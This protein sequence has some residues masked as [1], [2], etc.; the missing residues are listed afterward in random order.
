VK[1]LFDAIR[2]GDL[3]SM[4]AQLDQKPE[5]VQAIA[6]APPKKDAGQQPLQVAF[7]SGQLEIADLLL[8]RGADVNF[9]EVVGASPWTA[10][11]LHDAVRCAVMSGRWSLPDTGFGESMTWKAANTKERADR[12]FALL[13]R[14]LGLGADQ[15][16]HDSFGNST[17]A[18]ACMQSVQLLPVAATDA[19]PA[20]VEFLSDL[21]R[22]FELLLSHGADVDE[23]DPRH[24]KSVI[25]FHGG[26]PIGQFLRPR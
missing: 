7:K 20:T 4:R 19:K 18:V 17:L 16:A 15:R 5:L 23:I 8:D 6:K 1:A 24:G 22:I 26:S 9:Q 12:A 25:D 10:P 11:V 14:M 13:D 21:E 2:R 3:Q